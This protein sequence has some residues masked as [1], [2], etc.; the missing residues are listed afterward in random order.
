MKMV[1][2]EIEENIA[3][4]IPDSGA[5]PFYLEIKHLPEK[6][7]LG[8]V[9]NVYYQKENNQTTRL[10]EKLPNEA[11]QRLALMKAKREALLKRTKKN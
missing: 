8:D 5:A 2:E 10:I 11:E 1:L 7:Q 9:L 6:C 4:L 3:R